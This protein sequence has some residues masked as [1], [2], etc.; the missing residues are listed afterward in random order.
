MWRLN[1]FN[2]LTYRTCKILGW[3][4]DILSIKFSWQYGDLHMPFCS[5][6][7]LNAWT[8]AGN[9]LWSCNSWH[10]QNYWKSVI[11]TTKFKSIS[12]ILC[13]LNNLQIVFE[14][15]TNHYTNYK[16]IIWAYFSLYPISYTIEKYT[17]YRYKYI[18]KYCFYLFQSM[19]GSFFK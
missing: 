11:S 8:N 5:N 18:E 10:P 2:K 16:I 6:G 4:A 15:N 3:H 12:L 13:V 17:V 19:G 9:Q 14:L 7:L 1:S